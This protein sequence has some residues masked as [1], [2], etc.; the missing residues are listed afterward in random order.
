MNDIQITDFLA[1]CE[2]A[3]FT[4]AAEALH[5]SQ[6]AVS[7]Q[8]A[9]LEKELGVALFV[10]T[11]RKAKLS[12]AGKIYYAFFRR[13]NAE[14]VEITHHVKTLLASHHNSLKL[15]IPHN[16][17][18]SKNMP[19]IIKRYQENYPSL[20][21]SMETHGF[22]DLLIKLGAHDLDAVLTVDAAI[23]NQGFHIQRI[24][25]TQRALL[26]SVNHPLA[27]LISPTLAD[28][29]QETFFIPEAFEGVVEHVY[30]FCAPYGFKPNVKSVPNYESA[31]TMVA[32]GLGVF[33]ADCWCRELANAS[34]LH[35]KM[36]S[37][38]DVCLVYKKDMRDSLF[39]SLIGDI[40]TSM[41]SFAS[42]PALVSFSRTNTP[43]TEPTKPMLP[44]RVFSGSSSFSFRV[45]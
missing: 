35:I 34:F 32:N 6:P 12:E 8:I 1:V 25:Q 21:I 10:R 15:G 23:K 42:C 33:F 11:E 43:S 24:A 26:Y 17:D 41:V 27:G 5:V 4:K 38:H 29:R 37:F 9:A 19:Q 14:F 45:W 31:I 3:S 22:R 28:F 36:S 30:S 20:D 39:L 13:C 16:W 44:D 40:V 18:F 7:R 2:Y